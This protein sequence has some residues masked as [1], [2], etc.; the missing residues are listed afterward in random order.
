[1][2]DDMTDLVEVFPGK[3]NQTRCFAHILN[4][5]AKTVIKVFDAPKKKKSAE[6]GN[7]NVNDAEAMLAKLAQ[8]IELEEREMRASIDSDGADN[9]DDGLKDEIALLSPEEWTEFEETIV[10]V[11]LVIVKV[12]NFSYVGASIT[13]HTPAAQACIQDRQL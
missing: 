6:G 1:M 13:H 12:S 5:V 2:I 11:R 7:D 3:A 8:G 10:P 4:L 9:D